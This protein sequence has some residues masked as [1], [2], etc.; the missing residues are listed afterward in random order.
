M[1]HLNGAAHT[2]ESQNI[3]YYLGKHAIREYK[4]YFGNHLLFI[5]IENDGGTGTQ[6]VHPEEGHH[7]HFSKNNN[8]INNILHPGLDREL[9]TGVVISHVL[10]TI[11]YH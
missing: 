4:N 2:D 6:F 3:T 1:W 8:F 10:M 11:I 5:P 9:M 7:K